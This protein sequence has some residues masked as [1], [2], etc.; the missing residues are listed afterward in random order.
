MNEKQTKKGQELKQEN[1]VLQE[2]EQI[3]QRIHNTGIK[4]KSTR[5]DSLDSSDR[6]IAS[7][8]TNKNGL[9]P[10]F[11]WNF[12]IERIEE[13]REKTKKDKEKIEQVHR[14]RNKR[15]QTKKQP[16]K[17]KL[18]IVF[19]EETKKNEIRKVNAFNYYTD[20]RIEKFMN[21][22]DEIFENCMKYAKSKGNTWEYVYCKILQVFGIE[23][24]FSQPKEEVNE[25]NKEEKKKKRKKRRKKKKKKKKEKILKRKKRG[26]IKKEKIKKKI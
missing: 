8:P 10:P 18:D 17:P 12:P 1:E 7:L 19:K 11:V 21:L 26:K 5:K 14:D 22:F 20:G 4:K 23:Y 16:P 9:R 24:I 13:I 2:K 6:I 25:E 3:Y 15:M